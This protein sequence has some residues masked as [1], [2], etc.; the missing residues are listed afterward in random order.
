LPRTS[1]AL[2]RTFIAIQGTIYAGL[3][4]SSNVPYTSHFIRYI[5]SILRLA[6]FDD[7]S[8]PPRS[9]F[10]ESP[11]GSRWLHCGTQ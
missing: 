2:R 11:N 1:S 6:S 3:Q 8:W 7:A 10:F 5:S 4:V 9:A